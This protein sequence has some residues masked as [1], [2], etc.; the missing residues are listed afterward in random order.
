[1]F[2]GQN[3]WVAGTASIGWDGKN[4]EGKPVP[5]ADY[6]VRMNVGDDL[7]SLGIIRTE[8]MDLVVAAEGQKVP[9]AHGEKDMLVGTL[10]LAPGDGRLLK[11]CR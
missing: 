4:P 3:L 7:V 8:A 9:L 10:E 11:I 2:S 6:I 5:D 1:M